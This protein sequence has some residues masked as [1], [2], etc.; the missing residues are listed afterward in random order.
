MS[1]KVTILGEEQPKEKKK[2]E[3][4]YRIDL[5]NNTSEAQDTPNMYHNL[6]LIS[7]NYDGKGNDL[8]FAWDDGFRDGKDNNALYLGNFND[9]EV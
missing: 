9:G 8:M 4:I 5:E 3:F 2:I 1:T 6:I 7:R